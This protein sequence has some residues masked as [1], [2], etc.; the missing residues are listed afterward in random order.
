MANP[1]ILAELAATKARRRVVGFALQVEDAEE[2]ARRKLVA[3]NLD[4]VVLD[5]PSALGAVRADFRMLLANGE[6]RAFPGV[7]KSEMADEI[8]AFLEGR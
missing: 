7:T 4:A 3:K 8:I 6:I 2:R 1:D 5:D